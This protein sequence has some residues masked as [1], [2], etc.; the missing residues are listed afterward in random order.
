MKLKYSSKGHLAAIN[1]QSLDSPCTVYKFIVRNKEE[2]E[3][4]FFFSA[5]LLNIHTY[6]KYS[7]KTIYNKTKT[8]T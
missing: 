4:F 8:T 7:Q 2:K 3:N 6:S 1:S 5:T